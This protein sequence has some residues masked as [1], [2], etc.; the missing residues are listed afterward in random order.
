VK[1]STRKIAAAGSGIK[2]N[3]SMDEALALVVETRNSRN[4]WTMG[5]QPFSEAHFATFPPEL[6]ERCIKAGC[7]VGGVVLD[8]FGGSGTTAMVAA[9]LGRSAVLIELNPEYCTLARARIEAAFMGKDEGQRHMTRQL[10]RS[11]TVEALPLFG[12]A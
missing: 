10:G 3:S 11:E 1:G 2:N 7:P 8:P 5:T 12:G 6:A 9:S 4:V